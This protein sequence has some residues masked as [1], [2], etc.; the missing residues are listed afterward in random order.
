MQ[1]EKMID[2]TTTRCT[3][4]VCTYSTTTT[5]LQLFNTIN[6]KQVNDIKL[7][8]EGIIKYASPSGTG[9]ADQ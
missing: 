9:G 8:G 6:L 4:L 2:P 7:M 5:K 3:C 1:E